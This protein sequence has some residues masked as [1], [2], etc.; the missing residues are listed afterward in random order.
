MRGT[1][2]PQDLLF[3]PEIE[4]TA[5]RN[6]QGSRARRREARLR[7]REAP[8]PPPE[9]VVEQPGVV[10]A[11]NVNE[12][13]RTLRDYSKATTRGYYGSIVRPRVE[14][15]SITIPSGL[16]QVIQQNQFAGLPHEDPNQH[17]EIFV[18]LCD[19][20]QIDGVSDDAIYLRLF[21]FSLRDRARN[22]LSAQPEG[23]I[24]TWADLTN[25]F[26]NKFFPTSKAAKLRSEIT[27]FAQQEGETL[28]DAWE[29]FKD[30]LRKCP[31][32]SLPDWL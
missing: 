16:L 27:A 1:V 22:W 20:V 32:H 2:D 30:L 25:K 5:R 23:S 24:T 7:Q 19:T 11:D 15:H 10:M 6:R 18:Q 13:G 29:R 4:R 28:Y 26:V 21:T 9:P 8:Q 3:D 17:L 14:G 31:Q 12:Q